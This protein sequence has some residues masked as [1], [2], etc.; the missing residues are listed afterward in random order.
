MTHAFDRRVRIADLIKE[1]LA[2]LLLT[3][4]KDPRFGFVSVT[5]VEVVKDYSNA[6][7]FV[8][9]L[10]DQEVA[11]VIKALNKASGYFRYQLAHTLNL[12]TTPKLYFHYDETIKQGQKIM[13]LLR[14]SLKN[15]D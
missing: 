2:R 11:E 13:S 10:N 3:D 4:S 15:S 6:Q 14:Q 8:T 7:V 9:I 12:R 5:S 1:E